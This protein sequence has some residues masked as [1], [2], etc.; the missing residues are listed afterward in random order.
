MRFWLGLGHLVLMVK[1]REGGEGMRY[2]HKVLTRKEVQ[3][4]VCLPTRIGH[5]N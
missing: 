1:G 5:G 4:C 2:V 3:E